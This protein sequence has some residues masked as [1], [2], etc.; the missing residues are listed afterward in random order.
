MKMKLAKIFRRTL[1]MLAIVSVIGVTGLGVHLWDKHQIQ[2]EIDLAVIHEL[3]GFAEVYVVAEAITG[4]LGVR[5]Q[6]E[7]PDLF[8]ALVN[9]VEDPRWPDTFEE[10][11][12]QMRPEGKG[13]QIDAMCDSVMEMMV[14]ESGNQALQFAYV[15]LKAYYAGQWQ[16]TVGDAHSWATPQAA[17]DHAY[18]D[19]LILE[20]E[21][22]GHQYFSGEWI[23]PKGETFVAKSLRPVARPADLMAEKVAALVA[24]N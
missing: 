12:K 5:Y 9:R 15:A 24:A 16:S 22:F 21:S 8:S 11:I 17:E 19:G 13:C 18:F 6:D 23:N 4:E 10:V 3:D 1:N 14:S 2:V 20:K 7:W